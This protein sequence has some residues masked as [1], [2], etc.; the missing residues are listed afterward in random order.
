MNFARPTLDHDLVIDLGKAG[1]FSVRLT[2]HETR[3]EL[4]AVLNE[5]LAEHCAA[6]GVSDSPVAA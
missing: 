1:W 4:S 2:G 6:K 5:K 3:D